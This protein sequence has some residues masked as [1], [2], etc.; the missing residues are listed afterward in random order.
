MERE[1]L[2]QS[3]FFHKDFKVFYSKTKVKKIISFC[4]EISEMNML[5]IEVIL[6]D[7][8]I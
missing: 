3:Y 5:L 2:F 4:F 8:F 6:L 7:L 1:D